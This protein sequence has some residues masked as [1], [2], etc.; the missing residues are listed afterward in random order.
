MSAL[1]T[2]SAARTR[3]QGSAPAARPTLFVVAGPRL[4]RSVVP[5]LLTLISVMAVA[6]GL[7]LYLNTQMAVTSY[8]IRDTRAELVELVETEQTLKAEVETLGSP[9]YLRKAAGKIG[10]EPA[11]TT[12]IMNLEH[13][14]I[15]EL[16]EA[17]DK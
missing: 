5:F 4:S 7:T 15:T 6:M 9:E 13:E 16:S 1:P 10:M 8:D 3:Q 2:H 17:D 11:A 14:S 12:F